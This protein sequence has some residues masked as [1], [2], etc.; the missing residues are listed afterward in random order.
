MVVPARGLEVGDLGGAAPGMG[1]D[2]VPFEA[3]PPV[4]TRDRASTVP[5]SE[6]AWT[7]EA[8][9]TAAG[10]SP[11]VADA[12][13]LDAVDQDTLEEGVVEELPG[14]GYR[15]VADALDR[16]HSPSATNLAAGV[17]AHVDHDSA[18]RPA[19]AASTQLDDRDKASAA[20]RS[21][22]S[23]CRWSRSAAR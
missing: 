20:C 14:D 11:E 18:G 10:S 23:W 17:A 22:G 19:G 1:L 12:L 16:A 15:D 7:A 3:G 5:P 2:V 6:N 4:T 8:V 21:W 13:D 9:R